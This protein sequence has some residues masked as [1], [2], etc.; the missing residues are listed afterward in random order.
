MDTLS[1]QQENS[2]NSVL[3]EIINRFVIWIKYPAYGRLK[4]KVKE[5]K[6]RKPQEVFYL[7]GV[8]L[9]TGGKYFPKIYMVVYKRV[10]QGVSYYSS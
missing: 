5:N 2:Q 6:K 8:P 9:S 4:K 7:Y 3:F 1:P 10:N